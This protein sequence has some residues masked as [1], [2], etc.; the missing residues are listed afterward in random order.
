[1]RVSRTRFS[2]TAI[3]FL[4]ACIPASVFA[5]ATITSPAN[6]TEAEKTKLQNLVSNGGTATTKQNFWKEY[7]ARRGPHAVHQYL[8]WQAMMLVQK[9]PAYKDSGFPPIEEINR[10]DGQYRG[11]H[12]PTERSEARQPGESTHAQMSPPT[13]KLSSPGPDADVNRAGEPNPFYNGAAH[14]WNPW[15]RSGGAPREAGG[16]YVNLVDA[17]HDPSVDMREKARLAC[18]MAHY[19][20]DVSSLKHADAFEIPVGVMEIFENWATQF[21]AARSEDPWAWVNHKSVTDALAY[22]TL[23]TRTAPGGANSDAYWQRVNEQIGQRPMLTNEN[24]WFLNVHERTV[25][26]SV[27]AYLMYLAGRPSNKPL[28]RFY[29]YFDPFYFN[30]EIIDIDAPT[31]SATPVMFDLCTPFSE[32]LVFESNPAQWKKIVANGTTQLEAAIPSGADKLFAATADFFSLED[33]GKKRQDAMVEAMSALVRSCSEQSHGDIT[34]RIDFDHT[35]F[36]DNWRVAIRHLAS[37]FRACI[38]GLRTEALLIDAGMGAIEGQKKG[39]RARFRNIATAPAKLQKAV[40]SWTPADAKVKVS[41]AA[42]HALGGQ[43]LAPGQVVTHTWEIEIPKGQPMPEFTVDLYGLYDTIPDSGWWRQ[44]VVPGGLSVVYGAGAAEG[45]VTSGAPVDLVVVFDTTG[46]MQPSIDSVKAKTEEVIRK[47]HA[48]TGDLRVGLVEFRDFQDKEAK[49][50]QSWGFDKWENQVKRIREFKAQGG[51]DTP[52]DQYAAIMKGIEM[53]WR[54]FSDA[55]RSVTKLIVVVTD[56]E[57]KKPDMFGNTAAKVA[58]AAFDLD[59]AHIYTI[60]VG[61]SST[62]LADAEELAKLS[63]GAVLTAASGDEVAD[64]MLEAVEAGIEKHAEPVKAAPPPKPTLP[65]TTIYYFSGGVVLLAGVG[66]LLGG[67]AAKPAAPAAV[68]GA[69]CPKCGSLV[70]AGR[71]FC[72]SCGTKVGS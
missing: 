72:S 16:L 29:N 48:K 17:I 15:L 67:F 46:S 1:V 27:A 38:T 66:L 30:G 31:D 13:Y 4:I 70:A 68:G 7:E 33:G 42:D 54:D 57:A 25:R 14:Y 11:A 69:A 53:E 62:A 56:A 60:V 44:K 39:V 18:Y 3:V 36:E 61:S 58:K 21:N 47:L 50:L 22:L 28:G 35:R 26:S 32:H 24:G 49:P 8:A 37:A 45:K 10:W 41:P 34:G 9:D 52:E 71:K 64:K 2:D 23:I 40:L 6:I 63:D 43:N 55:D 51:G 59:P 20:G 5:W 19:I 65:P 12:G